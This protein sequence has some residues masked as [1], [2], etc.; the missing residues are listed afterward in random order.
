MAEAGGRPVE[1]SIS[2]EVLVEVLLTRGAVEIEAK[3]HAVL[4]DLPGEVVEDLVVAVDTMAGVAA[5]GAELATP[6]TE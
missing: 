1:S 2:A 5:G 6:L 4:I 3:L